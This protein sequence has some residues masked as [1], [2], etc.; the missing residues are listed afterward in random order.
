MRFLSVI[1]CLWAAGVQGAALGARS[2]SQTSNV[3]EVQSQLAAAADGFW[4]SEMAGKGYAAFNPNP[5]SYKV[6]RNVRD[7]GAVGKCKTS[8]D[9]GCG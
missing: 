7:Y 8:T 1:T 5:S 2:E 6:F 4:M 3:T 9:T